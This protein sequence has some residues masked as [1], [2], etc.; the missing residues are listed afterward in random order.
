MNPQD[1]REKILKL[2]HD[3][4]GKLTLKELSHHFNISQ[5]ALYK[6]LGILEKQRY[7]KKV[8]GGIELIDINMQ[9][10]NYYRSLQVNV[11]Q[12]IAIA[13][14]AAKLINSNETIFIDGSSTTFYLCEE[15]KKQNYKNITIITNSIFIPSEFILQENF[16]VICTGGMLNK[17]IGLYCGDLWENVLI[18]NFHANKFFFS[19]FGISADIGVL[20]SFVPG[21]TSMKKIFSK[22]ASKN[23]C[24]VDSG[25][26][27][28]KGAIN[29][30]SLEDIDVLISDN[31]IDEKVLNT[32]KTKNIQLAL[33][34]L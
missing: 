29:W 2:I 33:A 15:L 26:F 16:N 27:M 13:K 22:N 6:D 32:L 31:L 19:S 10:H 9:Q 20:D 30:I 24:L 18:N 12:K 14:E 28:I 11:R 5:S 4:D 34:N 17:E 7:I 23:I 8:Y 25:K 3:N 1:R 21:E